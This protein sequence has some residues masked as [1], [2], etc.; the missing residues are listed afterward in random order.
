MQVPDDM[1]RAEIEDEMPSLPLAY[2]EEAVSVP[3]NWKEAR[4]R[5]LRLSEPHEPVAAD[6]E[7]R[8]WPV[9]RV[10]GATGTCWSTPG[11]SPRR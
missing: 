1:L 5:Y 10:E 9:I 11:L 2:F 3:R 8:G 4:C 6:A 7:S